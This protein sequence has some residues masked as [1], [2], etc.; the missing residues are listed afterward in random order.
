MSSSRLGFA[1]WKTP[2]FVFYTFIKE[3]TKLNLCLSFARVR[4]KETSGQRPVL[5]VFR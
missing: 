5:V 4:L 1:F 3:R 2:H